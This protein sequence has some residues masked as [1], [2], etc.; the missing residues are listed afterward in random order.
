MTDEDGTAALHLAG[1]SFESADGSPGI[2]VRPSV[3]DGFPAAH[4]AVHAS[5][6]VATWGA[7]REEAVTR[8]ER[9]IDDYVDADRPGG[10]VETEGVLG[11]KPRVA[12]SRIGVL[13]IVE[14]YAV[15]GSL[16]E[17]A[18]AFSGP[19]VV[20]EVREAL[21]WADAHPDMVRGLREERERFRERIRREWN[22]IAL[23]D[24][25]GPTAYRNPDSPITLAILPGD[26]D[27]QDDVEEP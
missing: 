14:K 25:A 6:G 8:V 7:T 27:D 21:E 13:H 9:D 2:G 19:L 12:G 5:T 4:L 23:P 15:T 24:E 22:P 1:E 18:A 16:V 26:R 20:E 11:G 17:T 3:T 10:I